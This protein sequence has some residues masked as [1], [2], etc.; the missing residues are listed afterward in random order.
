M[1]DPV[2]TLRLNRFILGHI[3]VLLEEVL[4][5]EG[6]ADA[7]LRGAFRQHRSLGKRDRTTIGETIFAT[8]RH[9]R[10]LRALAGEDA[11]PMRLAVAALVRHLGVDRETLERFLEPEQVEWAEAI[12]SAS[13]EDLPPAVQ[14]ELPDW[15]YERLV[16]A[17]GPER[18]ASL[19][20]ALN[21]QA[22]L[23]LRVNTIKAT[24]DDVIARLAEEG[25]AAEPTP[26]SPVGVRLRDKPSLV[27]SPLMLEGLAEVQDEGS[28]LLGYLVAP[29]RKEMVADFCAG[30]G[31]KTLMI[32]AL[33]EST[34]RL[35]AMDVAA[36]RLD[37]LKPRAK[38]AGLS[39]I[40]SIVMRT[41]NDIRVKRLAGKLDRVLVDAPCTGLGT[42][43]RN[44]DLKWKQTPTDVEELSAKQL[45]I[46]TG[47]ARLPKPGGRLVYAT[48]SL[49]P[50][51]NRCVVDAFL[52]EHPDF[53][54]I[55]AQEALAERGVTLE[56]GD[57]FAVFPDT[58][59]TDGFFATVLQRDADAAG[60][61]DRVTASTERP[62]GPS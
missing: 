13:I 59:D 7:V 25:H 17:Y 49:L 45:R 8:L 34:G 9:L 26:L 21:R 28:Q 20:T 14:L 37:R 47:A 58:D 27:G 31:G 1:S 38:R 16:E 23:D 44:P 39:N 57:E 61:S 29:R 6:P 42:L 19:A 32:G 11:S 54:R 3:D 52:D 10:S 12:R 22:P 60:P 30:A 24:R 35:Y 4:R 33:M 55:S 41:E 46:L 43:R 5:F 62:T 15:L 53:H 48:C 18:T 51:E 50:E 2:P 40:Q 56:C 36:R